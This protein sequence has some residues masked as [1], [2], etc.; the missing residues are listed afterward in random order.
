MNVTCIY[1]FVLVSYLSTNLATGAY[2][3]SETVL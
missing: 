1:Y 2:S 3:L